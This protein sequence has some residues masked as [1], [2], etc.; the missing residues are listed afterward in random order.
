MCSVKYLWNTIII[1][2]L[3]NLCVSR[4]FQIYCRQLLHCTQRKKYRYSCFWRWNNAVAHVC[5]LRRSRDH[6]WTQT[7]SH[8]KPYFR[9]FRVSGY[10][11]NDSSRNFT[12]WVVSLTLFLDSQARILAGNC[13]KLEVFRQK[14]YKS[15]KFWEG[16]HV[17]TYK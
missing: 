12:T 11:L 16:D 9:R 17:I 7:T 1:T 5:Y 10:L 4:I 8:D 14:G 2:R 13:R 15:L 6:N 3:C